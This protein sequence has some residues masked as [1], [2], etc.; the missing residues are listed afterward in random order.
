MNLDAVETT[1][2]ITYVEATPSESEARRRRSRVESVDSE[3]VV[4]I[5][6]EERKR[7]I[8]SSVSDPRDDTNKLSLEQATSEGV[9]DLSSGKYLNP[10]TGQ[11]QNVVVALA[12][13]RST[14][15]YYIYNF[16]SPK[17]V[18]RKKCKNIYTKKISHTRSRMSVYIQNSSCAILHI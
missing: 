9:V 1:E 13:F 12:Y 18:V 4:S 16:C 6:Q 2:E 14:V 5:S 7:Y 11:G 3:N 15:A 8:V 10:D 17:K